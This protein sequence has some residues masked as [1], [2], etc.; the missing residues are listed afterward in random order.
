MF[1]HTGKKEKCKDHTQKMPEKKIKFRQGMLVYYIQQDW[2]MIYTLHT[3]F[4][5]FQILVTGGYGYDC[6]R[7][8][9]TSV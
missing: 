8:Y 5:I 9:D 6:I 3:R 1:Y 7:Y 4:E 2:K